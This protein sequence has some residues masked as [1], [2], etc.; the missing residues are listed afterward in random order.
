MESVSLLVQMEAGEVHCSFGRAQEISIF[1]KTAHLS[2]SFYI[3]VH[4]GSIL[5]DHVRSHVNGN[6]I[7][8]RHFSYLGNLQWRVSK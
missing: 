2:F 5:R 3:L 7:Y 6:I 1:R 8:W 4:A